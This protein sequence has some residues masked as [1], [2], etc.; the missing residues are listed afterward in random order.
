MYKNNIL[1]NL[2]VLA[3]I[4]VSF[5]NCKKDKPII[6][7]VSEF[8]EYIQDEMDDQNIP[9]ISILAFKESTILYEKYFGK[10]NID[11]NI[12]LQ[13]NHLFLLASV[14]KVITATA[15][16]Q[17]YDDG[18]FALDDNIN[19]YLTFSVSV[20]N[21]TT[22]I[23]FRML[24]TH[25]SGIADGSA[26][27]GQYFYGQDSPTSLDYFLEN[28][29]VNGGAYYNDSE[30]FHDFTPGSEH[31][32]SNIGNALIAL[33]VGQISGIDFNSYCKQNIFTPLG[34]NNSF[35]RL[36]EISQTIVTPYNYN[37]REFEAI[38][39]YT[40][41]DY[42]NGGLR[43]T[44]RDL[45]IF[46]RAFTQG[47]KSNDYQLLSESTIN[48]MLTPQ[49][50]TIDNE[51]GLHLFLMDSDYSLWGHDGGE[52]GVATIM[53]INQKTKVGAIILTNQGEVDLDEILVET[54]KL[55]L[56]L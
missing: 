5:I 6:K 20:P 34:M 43:S 22:N 56:S 28:Y 30:N 37:R 15:L 41:T 27:D 40:F 53:A 23:T 39:H 3:F 18:L 2:I 9:A 4:L 11:Q 8:E 24:L 17:L 38:Q 13:N 31:E 25:T 33:L 48:S 19:D 51:V 45:F 35:W 49:I 54:Y 47:G 21:Y 52:Q 14:S 1:M 10:S 46:L 55:G 42:P 12:A 29:L 32:Y 16:L 36:D 7:S 44:S 50:S 26:L